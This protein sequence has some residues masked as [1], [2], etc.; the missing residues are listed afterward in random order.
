MPP[1]VAKDPVVHSQ[2]DKDV[3][4]FSMESLG[5]FKIPKKASAAAGKPEEKDQSPGITQ[6]EDRKR[7]ASHEIKVVQ[8]KEWP[9]VIPKLPLK[10]EWSRGR[11]TMSIMRGLTTEMVKL[12]DLIQ[13][14][15]F[16]TIGEIVRFMPQIPT[17][18]TKLSREDMGE[19]REE[20]LEA[21]KEGKLKVESGQKEIQQIMRF[22]DTKTIK[23][24]VTKC[25]D[26]ESWITCQVKLI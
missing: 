4:G 10:S 23:P 11:K 12:S 5:Q 8:P 16:D 26:V 3:S 1:S 25:K 6:D 2:V 9:G 18:Y 22:Y 7:G 20:Y 21:V 24:L 19:V 15:W 13:E 14:D 17:V